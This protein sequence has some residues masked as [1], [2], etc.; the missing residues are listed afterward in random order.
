MVLPDDYYVLVLEGK[1]YFV[2]A[3]DKETN[4]VIARY[5]MN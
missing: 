2:V 5:K 4:K 1:E 3:V